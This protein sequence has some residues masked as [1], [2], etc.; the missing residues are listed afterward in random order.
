MVETQT[1]IFKENLRAFTEGYKI[2]VNQGGTSSSKTFSIMQLITL[3]CMNSAM[4]IVSCVS[5]SMPHLKRGVIRDFLNILSDQYEDKCFNKSDHIYKFPQAEIEFFSAD[6][7][8]KLRGGRR[9]HLFLNE[10]NNNSKEIFDQLDVRTSGTTF[11]DYNPS[12]D[13]WCH[14]LLQSYGIT[15]FTKTHFPTE[16]RDICFI[17]STYL[18]AKEFLPK[19]IVEKIE[20]RKDR[21]PNWWRVYGLGLIGSLEGLIH[22]NFSICDEMP[23]DGVEVFGLDFGFTD[24]C[25]LVWC[26]ITGDSI[27]SDELIYKPGMTN[28][29]L[30]N[31]MEECGLVKYK[32]EIFA[33]DARPESIEELHRMGWNI[34]KATKGK[35]SLESGFQ[36]LNQFKQFWTKSSLNAIKEQRNYM[37]AK[38]KN[39]KTIEGQPANNGYDHLMDARRYAIYSILTVQ[40]SFTGRI[41]L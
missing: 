35:D 30:S 26:K 39:G 41:L 6:Q 24:P 13:F 38:D 9:K 11:L 8:D 20:L 3:L 21:D 14:E 28:H 1:R 29:D 22:C 2:I 18:D 23:M 15:D 17:H 36:M 7:A 33:D 27:Y 4:G 12:S 32:D 37:Y 31:K 19:K 40:K 34:K 10:C 16:H 25:A 5:E